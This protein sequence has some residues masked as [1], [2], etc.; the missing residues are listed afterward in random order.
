MH[1]DPGFLN[2]LDPRVR[3]D[4]GTKMAELVKED[5]ILVTVLYPMMLKDGGPPF[6]IGLTELKRLLMTNAFKPLQ[7]LLAFK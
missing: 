7:L 1:A 2:A 5:G 3:G 6:A 4:Y